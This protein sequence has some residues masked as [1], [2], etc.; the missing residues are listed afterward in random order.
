MEMVTIPKQ[1]YERLKAAAARLHKLAPDDELLGE[2]K[3][4]FRRARTTPWKEA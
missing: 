1:E 3:E 4:S 2:L